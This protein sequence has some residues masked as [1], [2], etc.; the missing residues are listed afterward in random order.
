MTHNQFITVPMEFIFSLEKNDKDQILVNNS[1]RCNVFIETEHG[2]LKIQL[3]KQIISEI[4]IGI[5]TI[6][7]SEY[8]NFEYENQFD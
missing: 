6:K 3:T 2:I 5:N 8:N 7:R 1:I 4:N